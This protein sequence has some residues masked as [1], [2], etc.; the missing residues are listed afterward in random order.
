M[1][2]LSPPAGWTPGF[3]RARLP[4]P[5]PQHRIHLPRG[6]GRLGGSAELGHI[7]SSL[8][9]LSKLLNIDAELFGASALGRGGSGGHH[10]TWASLAWVPKTSR[11]LGLLGLRPGGFLG[12]SVS[13]W[14]VVHREKHS[15]CPG[16]GATAQGHKRLGPPQ[17]PSVPR[18]TQVLGPPPVSPAPRSP[19][20]FTPRPTGVRKVGGAVTSCSWLLGNKGP[21]EAA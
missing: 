16:A 15:K 7:Y 11:P 1:G 10:C 13:A 12:G 9:L 8:A 5:H 17:G 2:P 18:R 3:C 4:H 21:Q 14:M 20:S 6:P 19:T